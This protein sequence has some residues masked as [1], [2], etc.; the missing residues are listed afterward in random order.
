MIRDEITTARISRRSLLKLNECCKK[1]NMTHVEFF[2]ALFESVHDKKW[3]KFY[4]SLPMPSNYVKPLQFVKIP[5][6][7][8]KL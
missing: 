7:Y 2:D 6:K 1:R 3:A 5:K 4:D 8:T